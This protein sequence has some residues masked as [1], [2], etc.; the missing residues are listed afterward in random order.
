MFLLRIT[1]AIGVFV[2]SSG[3]GNV[4]K[5]ISCHLT[6]K[7]TYQE[8]L[9]SGEKRDFENLINV[10]AHNRYQYGMGHHFLKTELNTYREQNLAVST[11]KK[12]LQHSVLMVI[13]NS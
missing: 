1:C 5:H 8:F 13:V 10:T 2:L 4:A 6:R 12:R 11:G 7:S 9:T 3:A